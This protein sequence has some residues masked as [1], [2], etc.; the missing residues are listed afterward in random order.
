MNENRSELKTYKDRQAK[1]RVIIF[2]GEI[3]SGKSTAALNL[4]KAIPN[5]YYFDKDELVHC[6]YPVFDV[7]GVTRDR[8]SDFFNK[9]IRQPEYVSTNAIVEKGLLF[10]D[11]VIVNAPYSSE[12]RATEGEKYDE[13]VRFGNT[14]HNLGG[15]LFL[16]YMSVSPKVMAQRIESRSK[17]DPAARERDAE[18]LD[19]IAEYCEAHAS[20]IPDMSKS[21]VVDR[22]FVFDSDFPPVSFQKLV[23]VLMPGNNGVEYDQ[24]IVVNLDKQLGR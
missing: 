21:P 16:V 17:D 15:E 11:T 19:H 13:F 10:N 7:G 14:I 24:K 20:K 4:A 8:H 18:I 12:L 3:A 5:S 1:K 23:D 6:T 2:T 22:M 9:W